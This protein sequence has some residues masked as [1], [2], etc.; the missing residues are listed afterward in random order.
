MPLARFALCG[1]PT[2]PAFFRPFLAPRAPPSP[3]CD[4]GC[5]KDAKG[6]HKRNVSCDRSHFPVPT[7]APTGR[8]VPGWGRQGGLQEGATQST[9]GCGAAGAWCGVPT[10]AAAAAWKQGLLGAAVARVGSRVEGA[11]VHGTT[12][13]EI[14][15]H[16]LGARGRR[17]RVIAPR[18]GRRRAGRRR[19][20]CCRGR[21]GCG[22]LWWSSP[23]CPCAEAGMAGTAGGEC[24]AGR[25][26]ARR[27]RPA[28]PSAVRMLRRRASH[29]AARRRHSTTK[30]T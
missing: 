21:T 8:D 13:S 12:S 20:C 5:F 7:P 19:R 6:S 30:L 18:P 3:P 22:F 15:S 4:W 14:A 26:A 16:A 27:G 10:E 17:G 11:R 28:R 23:A 1:A 9:A 24:R 25:A 2:R 29:P